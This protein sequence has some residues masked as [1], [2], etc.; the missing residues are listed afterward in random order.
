MESD[1]SKG[2]ALLGACLLT[3][4]PG[5]LAYAQSAPDAASTGSD[6]GPA[7]HG[8]GA[9][10]IV[11]T[12]NKREQRL[13]DVGLSVAAIS[14]D[15]LTTQRINTLEDIAHIV[16]GLVYSQ[17]QVSTPVYTLRGVG[18]NESTFAGYPD[19]S[20]YIDQIPLPLPVLSSHSA[21]DLERVEVLKGPQG[22]LFGNNATGGAVNLIAAKPKDE[23]GAGANLSYGRFNTVELNAYLTGPINNNL[24]ARLAVQVERSDDWQKSYTSKATNGEKN[25]LAGRFLLDWKPTSQL[26]FELN[27]NG[28]RDR[29]EPQAPQLLKITPQNPAGRSGFYGTVPADFPILLYP[30]TPQQPR[31]ADFTTGSN[32]STIAQ[33]DQEPVSKFSPYQ[34]NDFWQAALRSDFDVNDNIKM[35]SI[36]SYIR[37]NIESFVDLDGTRLFAQDFGQFG[38]IRSFSQELRLAGNG[39]LQWLVGANYERTKVDEFQV[40]YTGDTTSAIVNGSGLS[41]QGSNQ[42]MRNYAIFGNLE[43]EITPQVSI[44]GGI[45]R[46]WANRSFVG[47]NVQEPYEDPDPAGAGFS[48]FFNTLGQFFKSLG[49]FPNYQNVSLGECFMFDNRLDDGGNP[50]DP[51]TYGMAGCYNDKLK[52]KNTSWRVGVDYKATDDVLLYTNVSKGYKAGSFPLA[53]AAGWSQLGAV[54]Q[55]SLINYEVGFKTQFADKRI[56]LNGAAFYYDYRN[57]QLRSRIVDGVFGLLSS[58][59][60]VPKSTIKG[61][62]IE[63]GSRPIDGLSLGLSATYLDAKIKRYSGIVGADVD[64]V[65]GLNLPVY[66]SY[67]GSPLPFAPKWQMSANFRYEAEVGN[68]VNAFIGGNVSAQSKSYAVPVVTE[69]DLEDFKLSGRAIVGG[70]IGIAAPDGRWNVMLWGKNIF[71]KYYRTSTIVNYDSIRLRGQSLTRDSVVDSRLAFG[72]SLGRADRGYR[73]GM[74]SDRAAAAA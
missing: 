72:G 9:G 59:V 48:E 6:A 31:A 1:F 36:T 74:G 60:N 20:V 32:L 64:P 46:T 4:A 45:R 12:A 47:T 42:K 33:P 73:R 56:T 29:G 22:T 15:Q 61:A 25:N 43:F 41:V 52:E 44:K 21:Y 14:A 27:L 55:E 51:S 50:L 67:K 40:N 57:K 2:S 69:V 37:A 3:L 10:E 23:F 58:L 62:E 24:N 17:T 63:L 54:K 38:K 65:T 68:R 70:N 18:F 7:I 35:T 28:W 71:N 30:L 19:V 66:A 11:V 39:R 16:P 26:S 49:I 8:G 53:G 34:D 13:Q 5:S